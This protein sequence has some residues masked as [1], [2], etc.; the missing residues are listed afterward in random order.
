V[1]NQIPRPRA[2]ASIAILCRFPNYPIS[3]S[4]IPTASEAAFRSGAPI[5]A[6]K[7]L[8]LAWPQPRRICDARTWRQLHGFRREPQSGVREWPDG[9]ELGRLESVACGSPPR[10][11]YPPQWSCGR[12]AEGG[13]L[14][15]R[16]RVVKPYRGFESLRLRHPVNSNGPFFYLTAFYPHPYPHRNIERASY[17]PSRALP[18]TVTAVACCARLAVFSCRNG[19]PA[20]N[21][22]ASYRAR[23]FVLGGRG[24][25]SPRV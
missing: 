9:S 19:R 23:R 16:Y 11:A 5:A 14:L 8:R 4:R 3:S 17:R 22:R 13:G 7:F 12:E 18:G 10:R 24:L 6:E 2:P 15:N 20:S 1:N 21:R 25:A